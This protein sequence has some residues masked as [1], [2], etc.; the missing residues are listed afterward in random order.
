MRLLALVG[1][2][3]AAVV[4]AG[5]LIAAPIGPDLQLRRVDV[6]LLCQAT[7]AGGL[8]EVKLLAGP[9]MKTRTYETGGSILVQ[10]GPGFGADTL[11]TIAGDNP[12][13]PGPGVFSY[14]RLRC[15]ATKARIPLDSRGLV[16]PA[17]TFASEYQCDVA[18]RFV[19]RARATFK[20][21][22]GWTL[23]GDNREMRGI[24]RTVVNGAVA[25]R[26][27]PARKPLLFASLD[28][29]GNTRLLAATTCR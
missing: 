14:H 12:D 16:G 25:V 26:S 23:L 18:R 15:G 27:W 17:R 29:R 20:T 19:V 2:G 24:R 13:A 9:A 6:T 28:A 21:P 11:M 5:A 7:G 10:T 3:L 22:G 8:Y 4:V 1:A